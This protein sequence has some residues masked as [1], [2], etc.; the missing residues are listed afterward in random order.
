[1]GSSPFKVLVTIIFAIF[2]HVLHIIDFTTASIIATSLVH[3]RLVYF[4]S[5]CHSLA[6]TPPQKPPTNTA[7]ARAITRTPEHLHITPAL[8]LLHWFNVEECIQYK[9]ISISHNLLHKS[10]PSCL[11]NL[12]HI[13]PTSKLTPLSTSVSTF[14]SSHPSY[15]KLALLLIQPIGCHMLIKNIS[16]WLILWLFL[17]WFPSFWNDL[18]N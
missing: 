16:M 3:S 17:S 9:I 11:R 14:H 15:T 7:L 2:C 8:K 1:M 18:H 10:E 13:K 4:N 12:F 5:L 6:V